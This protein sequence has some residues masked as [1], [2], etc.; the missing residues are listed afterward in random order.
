MS[1]PDQFLMSF[2]TPFLRL[3]SARALLIG[4]AA[5]GDCPVGLG[6]GAPTPLR[7]GNPALDMAGFPTGWW[8]WSVV[9]EDPGPMGREAA[10]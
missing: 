7:P 3:A 4:T 9:A 5:R 2:D 1:P 6:S 8:G 10:D